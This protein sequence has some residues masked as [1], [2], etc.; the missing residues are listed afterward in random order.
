MYVCPKSIHEGF[1]VF[2]QLTKEWL[3]KFD[4]ATNCREKRRD[5]GK[6]PLTDIYS[7]RASPLPLSCSC[8]THRIYKVSVSGVAIEQGGLTNLPLSLALRTH[9][10][11]GSGFTGRAR[12][13]TVFLMPLFSLSLFPPPLLHS[14]AGL[15]GSLSERPVSLSHPLLVSPQGLPAR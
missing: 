7:W 15:L 14:A 9:K 5:G 6:T 8:L 1:G 10:G 12:V 2:S 4:E 11:P 13:A 3:G